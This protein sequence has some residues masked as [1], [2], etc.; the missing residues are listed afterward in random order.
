MAIVDVNGRKIDTSCP[1]MGLC[2]GYG[3]CDGECPPTLLDV[4]RNTARLEHEC[5]LLPHTD[6]DLAVVCEICKEALQDGPS[7]VR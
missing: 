2:W 3:G 4:L 5:E 1:K 6:P 7:T